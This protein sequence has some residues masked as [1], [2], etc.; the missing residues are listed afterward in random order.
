MELENYSAINRSTQNSNLA[1]P[2]IMKC[3]LLGRYGS[4]KSTLASM[5]ANNLLDNNI[6]PTIAM[7]FFTKTLQINRDQKVKVQ[8]W[9]SAGQEKF[10]SIVKSYLRDIFIAYIIFD[11]SNLDSWNDIDIWKNCIL[12]SDFDFLPQIVLVGTKSDKN[13]IINE[14]QIKNKAEEWNCNYYIVSCKTYDAKD[15]IYRMFLTETTKLHNIILYNYE[16]EKDLPP[17]I[18]EEIYSF[19]K[20]IKTKDSCC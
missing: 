20:P 3:V 1:N 10:K 19:D 4:G 6:A 18:L 16:M 7:D 11:M 14:E 8:I 15:K 12:P 5:F 9:D 17:N 13:N 2:Y